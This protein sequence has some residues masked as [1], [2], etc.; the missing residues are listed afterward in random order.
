[1]PS[2]A[3]S[4]VDPVSVEHEP[5][6]ASKDPQVEPERLVL[7][8]PDVELDPL[9]PRQRGAAVDLGPA[10]DAR[11]NL[12]PTALPGG[13]LLDLNGDRRTRADDRHL[14][15]EHIPQVRQLVE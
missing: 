8:V 12:Q 15:A 3:L 1:M 5:R 6:G 7:D 11:F 10:G 13:V 14:A 9:R 4:L 2:S